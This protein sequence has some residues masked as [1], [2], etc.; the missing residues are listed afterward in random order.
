[1]EINLINELFSKIC[2]KSGTKFTHRLVP[3]KKALEITATK[4]GIIKRCLV[5]TDCYMPHWASVFN[6]ECEVIG[7]EW[8][9]PTKEDIEEAIESA[10]TGLSNVIE[11]EIHE[12]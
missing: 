11:M 3:E 8:I 7:E 9:V 10:L 1:M 6:E 4:N 2:G 5:S 12:D